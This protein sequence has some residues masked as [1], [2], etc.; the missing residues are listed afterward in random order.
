MD[1]GSVFQHSRRGPLSFRFLVYARQQIHVMCYRWELGPCF[2]INQSSSSVTNIRFFSFVSFHRSNILWSVLLKCFVQSLKEDVSEDDLSKLLPSGI[3][4]VDFWGTMFVQNY[5]SKRQNASWQSH[6]HFLVD[7][8]KF[9][10]LNV[11]IPQGPPRPV[12]GIDFGALKTP[13][14]MFPFPFRYI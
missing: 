9:G 1:S 6:C 7:C 14:H 4:V 13:I 5:A 11:F 8:Q 10:I 3:P 2:T 12:K